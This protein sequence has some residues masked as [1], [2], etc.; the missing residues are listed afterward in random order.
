MDYLKL[1]RSILERALYAHRC[2]TLRAAF[3]SA[4]LLVG[5]P[6]G[7]QA[8]VLKIN[9]GDN[10]G[11]VINLSGEL[12]ASVT[13]TA[14]GLVIDIPGVEISLVCDT[15]TDPDGC[16]VTIGS[17][18]SNAGGST[19]ASD[20]T[21]PASDTTTPAS[22]TTTPASDDAQ[23][24]PAY[25]FGCDDLAAGGSNSDAGG[26]ST[27]TSDSGGSTGYVT[28]EPTTPS[29]DVDD[30]CSGT[31]YRPA[32]VTVSNTGA[33]GAAFGTGGRKVNN[34]ASSYDYGSAKRAPKARLTLAKGWVTTLGLSMASGNSPSAGALV[35]AQASNIQGVAL[36]AWIS[37]APDGPRVSSA[38]SYV[39]YP[40]SDLRFSINGT[41]ACNLSAGSSYYFNLALCASSSSDLYCNESGALAGAVDAILVVDSSY[42]D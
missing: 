9:P 39:G 34:V 18:N 29:P 22:D 11:N 7:A 31:G 19:P 32:C 8:A 20:T 36:R 26:G 33:T 24:D 4:A 16:T 42:N 41:A 17:G 10:A 27:G 1:L 37:T 25:D 3:M 38:C 15:N 23:C 35:F 2:Y 6:L 14:E 12:S 28:P 13:H 30:P 21:T 5:L 40:E